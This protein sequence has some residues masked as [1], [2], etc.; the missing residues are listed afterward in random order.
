MHPNFLRKMYNP[1]GIFSLKRS[2][3]FEIIQ[4]GKTRDGFRLEQFKIRA[5]LIRVKTGK[6]LGIVNEIRILVPLKINVYISNQHLLT[7]RTIMRD[8]LF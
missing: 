5:G 1:F 3:K 8:M 2:D 7:L 4:I 6:S